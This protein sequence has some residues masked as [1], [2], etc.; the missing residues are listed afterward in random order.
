MVKRGNLLIS[1]FFGIVCIIVPFLRITPVIWRSN[2]QW[3]YY[4]FY[5]DGVEY[6]RTDPD[7]IS[8]DPVYA[9]FESYNNFSLRP[10]YSY[11]G[12]LG[13]FLLLLGLVLLSLY[14]IV[15]LH[16]KQTNWNTYKILQMVILIYI[17]TFII[18]W[19]FFI[20]LT[21]DLLNKFAL[22][23]FPLLILQILAIFYTIHSSRKFFQ[24]KGEYYLIEERFDH[25]D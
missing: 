13:C 16:E 24:I 5:Y 4:L 12:F 19:M 21:N 9:Y 2:E 15:I 8:P 22:L 17:G 25:K 10:G 7:M 3:G 18:H 20:K 14:I 23:N 6:W 1:L 11:L